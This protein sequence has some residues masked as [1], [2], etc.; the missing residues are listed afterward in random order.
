MKNKLL[1]IL[2]TRPEIIKLSSFI[3]NSEKFFT[4]IL[5]NTNQNYDT[6]LNKVFF[7]DLGIRRPKYLL[8]TNKNYST[9][10]KISFF[11]TSIEKIIRKEKP[12]AA[13]YLGDTNTCYSLIPVKKFKIPIFHLEAGNRCYDERVPEEINRRFTDHISDIN[14]V[15][16]NHSKAN[17]LREGIDNYRIIQTGSPMMEVIYDNL[18][19]INSSKIL[20]DL[21]LL[22][23]KFILVSFHREE[24]L[25]NNNIFSDFKIF[26]INLLKKYKTKIVISTHPRLY[27]KIRNQIKKNKN[28]IFHKPF[29]FSDYIKLQQ[30]SL[31][32]LSDSGTL[33]E[34]TSILKTKSILL[35]EKHERP[36]GIDKG[37]LI[38]SKINS[39]DIFNKIDTIIKNKDQFDVPESYM[40]KN[41]SEIVIKTIF[42]YKDYVNN[43]IWK[44]V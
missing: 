25:D 31:I 15:Y 7:K 39:K 23:R 16:S 5:V 20:E 27:L 1:I 34:E 13:I 38:T 11:I 32:N 12:D 40:S 4:N 37:I 26:L 28:I 19:T 43:F 6:N 10:K 44:K 30:N 36:E 21:K 29:C 33:M 41:F 35:R 18:K 2:G 42:S 17:L 3:K 24:N 22:Q 9:N 8:K 14:L